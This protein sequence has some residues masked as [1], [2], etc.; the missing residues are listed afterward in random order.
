MQGRQGRLG[1]QS[2]LSLHGELIWQSEPGKQGRL[3][4]PRRLGRHDRQLSRVGK[5]GR[6]YLKGTE[7]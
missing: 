1:R 5:L 4:Q 6:L 3:G 2:R 7:L